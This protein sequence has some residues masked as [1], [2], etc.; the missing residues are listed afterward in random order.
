MPNLNPSGLIPLGPE[1]DFAAP[2]DRT[3]FGGST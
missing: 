1:L 3:R 2:H